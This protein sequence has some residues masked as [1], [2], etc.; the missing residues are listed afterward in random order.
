[1]RHI[2]LA[3]IGVATAALAASTPGHRV[4]LNGRPILS[5]ARHLKPGEY[6]WAPELA[7]AGPAL[8]IVNLETQRL[9]L[10]RDGL[11]IAASTVSSGSKGHETPTG[12][13]QILQKH[14][15]HYS[16]T[17][18]NAPMPNM[19]RLTWQG[20]ALHAGNLPGYPA[21]HGCVR[22]PHTFSELLFG[23]TQT[24]MTV[25]I[26]SH[27]HVPYHA[28]EPDVDMD[29]AATHNLRKSITNAPFEWNAK[30]SDDIAS[31]I[32]SKADHRAIVVRD[33]HQIG[34]APVYVH[35]Q[36]HGAMA[37]VLESWD[38]KGMHWIKVQL[39]GSG[40]GMEVG[41][42]EGEHFD[43]PA[44]FRHHLHSVLRPGSVIVVTPATL[45]SG[46]P[47]MKETVIDAT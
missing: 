22:L 15:E 21:S 40:R 2:S 34:S 43:A 1:M 26:T 7:P 27:P 13:F 16:S 6:V 19:Q 25:V 8:A 17:Y 11:P 32:I 14:A 9:V 45:R 10:F 39:S 23:A 12:V 5:V 30:P 47:D 37:Y 36:L 41:A 4:S 38:S 42:N 29:S 20:V 33:G 44:N 46:S 18:N 28:E 31:V 24:G 35:G 3:L